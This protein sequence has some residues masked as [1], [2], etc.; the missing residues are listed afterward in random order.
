MKVFL[1]LLLFPAAVFAQN[2]N[3]WGAHVA[4]LKKSTVFIQLSNGSCTGFVINDKAKGG[5]NGETDVDYVLTAAHCDGPTLFAAGAPA[6][7]KAK[8]VKKDLLVLEVENLNKPAVRLA[9][10]DP[11]VGDEIASFGFGYGLEEPMFRVANVA[12]DKTIIP[13]D[14][15][16]G[17]FIAINSTFVP[18]QS[19]G[20][21]INHNGEVVMIVQNGT[22]IVGFGVGAE[23]INDKM[24]RFFGA[25]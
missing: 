5:K 11:T 8:D 22:E 18:G 17:P 7:V 14:G 16:G 20:P 1:A 23:T 25:R 13:Y 2:I 9:E 24:G 12:N 4:A 21:V 15:V 10:H 19:G 3:I 6:T